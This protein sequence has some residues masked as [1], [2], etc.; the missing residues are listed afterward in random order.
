MQILERGGKL[1]TWTRRR[2][3]QVHRRRNQNQVDGGLS[4]RGRFGG[5][6]LKGVYA[7]RSY[8]EVYWHP[9]A[10]RPFRKSPRKSQTDGK[11]GVFT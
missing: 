4:A 6:N 7:V 8:F 3:M 11:D 5:R 2:C 10:F 1:E 9:Q